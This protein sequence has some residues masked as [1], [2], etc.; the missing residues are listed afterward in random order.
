MRELGFSSE[1]TSFVEAIVNEV[2]DNFRMVVEIVDHPLHGGRKHCF[3]LM[4]FSAKNHN[5]SMAGKLSVGEVGLVVFP[6]RN[7]DICYW[8]GTKID[9][10]NEQELQ[11]GSYSHGEDGA[12]NFETKSG[13]SISLQGEGD[14]AAIGNKNNSLNISKES[15]E[16]IHGINSMKMG[17]NGFRVSY[18]PKDDKYLDNPLQLRLTEDGFVAASNATVDISAQSDMF[19]YTQDNLFITAGYN[20]KSKK[21]KPIKNFYLTTST[22]KLNINKSLF[23]SGSQ[24]NVKL[25]SSLVGGHPTPGAAGNKSWSI[26][27]LGGDIEYKAGLGNIKHQIFNPISTITLIAGMK[28]PSTPGLGP[29]AIAGSA[30]EVGMTY[31]TMVTTGTYVNTNP[32]G[33]LINSLGLITE[34]ATGV[35]TKS[36]G[37]TYNVTSG[38]AINFTAGATYALQ[39]ATGVTVQSGTTVDILSATDLSLTSGTN[40]NIMAGAAASVQTSATLDI[41]SGAPTS[42]TSPMLNLTA[43]ST[44]NAGPKSVAPTGVGPFCAIPVCPFTGSPHQG[45][46]ASG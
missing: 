41:Q 23:I 44:I 16:L 40:I 10:A 13:A 32:S 33:I 42:I 1:N 34:T 24:V 9:T 19:L 3:R 37:A 11:A 43:A 26:N 20:D 29:I 14:N 27:V 46:I 18:H 28:T 12:I 6:E 39:A 21:H 8:L 7:S 15:I 5:S 4:P 30:V 22:A 2:I 25:G 38:A 45:P 31:T 35:I 17:L 36:A